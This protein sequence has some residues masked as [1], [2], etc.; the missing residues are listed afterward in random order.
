MRS[1]CRLLPARAAVRH[2]PAVEVDAD[3][4]ARLRMGQRVPCDA[5]ATAPCQGEAATGAPWGPG[6]PPRGGSGATGPAAPPEDPPGRTSSTTPAF[7]LPGPRGCPASRGAPSS[8]WVPSTGCTGAP[9][10][11]RRDHVAGPGHGEAGR[12]RDLPPASPAHRATRDRAPPAHHPAREEGDPGR[13]RA[14]LGGLRALHPRAFAALAPGLRGGGPPG[15]DRRGGARDRVRPRLRARPIGR[16]RHPSRDRGRAGL[17]RGRGGAGGATAM[18]CP[19]R[20][21][22]MRWPRAAWRRPG[23][24]WGAPTA[25]GAWWCGARGGGVQLGFPTANLQVGIRTSSSPRRGLRRARGAGGRSVPGGTPHWPPA[26]LRGIA[27]LGGT[28]PH[29]LRGDLYGDVVRVDVVRRLR[30]V[31][32]RIGGGPGGACARTWR[33]RAAVLA[34]T[35]PLTPLNP[36]AGFAGRGRARPES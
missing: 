14:G 22:A 11:A 7:G 17:R 15:P 13:E 1:S 2:L 6:R 26:H 27:A 23:P 20:A 5:S 12:A 25:S 10:G 24:P 32:L 3:G 8:R 33:R 28:A 34:T 36:W 29:G 4:E 31:A 18:P 19:R 21:F 9:R 35:T 16:R 30:G